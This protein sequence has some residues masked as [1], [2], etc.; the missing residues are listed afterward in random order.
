[1]CS[2]APRSEPCGLTAAAR[3]ISRWPAAH[4]LDTARLYRLAIEKAEPG[5]KYHAVA[6]EGIPFRDIAEA[7]GRGAGL[8]VASIPAADADAHFAFLSMF[9]GVDN[10]VSSEGTRKVLGWEPAHPGYIED[11]EHGHYMQ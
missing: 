1:M 3:E 2:T 7:I 8:P 11:L 9:V 5:A 10:P 6:E 4:V